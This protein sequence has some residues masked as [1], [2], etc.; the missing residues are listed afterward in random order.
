MVL[1]FFIIYMIV[2]SRENKRTSFKTALSLVQ[3]GE[4]SLALLELARTNDLIGPPYGQVMIVTIVISMIITPLILKNLSRLSDQF[5][6]RDESVEEP[7]FESDGYHDH[8]VILGFGEF[9]QNV[10]RMLKESGEFYLAIENK[11]STVQKQQKL[12]EPIMFGNATQKEILKKADIKKAKK[13]IVAID[14]P[15]KMYHICE[16]LKD[17]ID[18]DKIIVKVHSSHEKEQINHLGIKN[19]VVENRITSEYIAALDS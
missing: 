1:K 16:I 4:F 18:P 17:Y 10:A 19:I 14:N 2:R 13:V 12:G 5:A 3:V 9:G 7:V 8:T 6:K 15:D 11:V